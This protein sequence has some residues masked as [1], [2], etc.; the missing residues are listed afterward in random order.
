MEG[1]K[2]N[3]KKDHITPR[4]GNRQHPNSYH[5]LPNHLGIALGD[6]ETSSMLAAELLEAGEAFVEDIE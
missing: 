4:H 3:D 5:S 1:I 6:R 2:E